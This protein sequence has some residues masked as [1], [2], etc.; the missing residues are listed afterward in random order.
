[1]TLNYLDADIESRRRI[2]EARWD[3]LAA[4]RPR[5]GRAVALQRRTIGRQFDLLAAFATTA[6]PAPPP[7]AVVLHRLADGIPVLRAD[8]P[9]LPVDALIPVMVE[10]GRA[11]SEVS[12]VPA[13]ARA[14]VLLARGEVDAARLLALVFQRDEDAVRQL[15]AEHAV[16]MDALWLIADVALAPLAHLQQRVALRE[17]EPDS[18]VREAL[19]RWDTGFCPACGSWPALAEVAYGERLLRCAF[20]ACAWRM[21][22]DRCAFCGTAGERF[23]TVTP[24]RARPSRRL[25]LCRQ[26]GG[27]LKVL[28]VD[29]PAPFPL[30]A[31]DD[32]ATADLDQAA[33]H[34]G[35]RRHPLPRL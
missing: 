23:V 12:G 7:E 3:D 5:L 20:C 9:P 17:D 16:A 26:C 27:F 28:T 32:L 24:D 35:Y 30:P 6:L 11:V 19:E 33:M 21:L 14:A 8:L 18:P 34:H 10:L 31:I 13:G 22:T 4:A 1:L 15:A 25:E 2:A 29:V